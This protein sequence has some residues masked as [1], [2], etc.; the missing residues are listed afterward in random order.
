MM[1]FEEMQNHF[2]TPDQETKTWYHIGNQQPL[3]ILEASELVSDL[4]G[5]TDFFIHQD[6]RMFFV[7]L[8]L[9]AVIPEG[10]FDYIVPVDAP[11]EPEVTE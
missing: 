1:T 7:G 8:D 4:E 10:T 3:T 2:V 11:A 5:V 6:K 9:G